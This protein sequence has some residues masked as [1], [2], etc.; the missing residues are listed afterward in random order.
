MGVIRALTS[1][2]YPTNFK[3]LPWNDKFI[4]LEHQIKS[5]KSDIVDACEKVFDARSKLDRA[6]VN[7]GFDSLKEAMK[8][9]KHTNIRWGH[10]FDI[11]EHVAEITDTST[12]IEDGFIRIHISADLFDWVKVNDQDVADGL[13]KSL[14][15][16][17]GE[18]LKQSD[19]FKL[20]IPIGQEQYDEWDA[21]IATHSIGT[22]EQT[23]NDTLNRLDRIVGKSLG[24]DDADIDFI[25]KEL[26]EDAFLKR[27]KPRYPGKQTRK[28]GFRTGL[29][30]SDRYK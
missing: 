20:I 6:I 4:E 2:I 9:M 24:L 15:L 21:I 14:Q 5:L 13:I 3:L 10:S 17:K 19:I 30:S 22:A 25:Q 7:S 1:H 8:K 12:S 11:S 18:S 23:M 26:R 16:H 27:I 28:Q 29:D